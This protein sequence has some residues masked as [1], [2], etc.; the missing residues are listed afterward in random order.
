MLKN[1]KVGTK[2]ATGFYNQTI[3]FL[4]E[5]QITIDI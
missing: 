2:E 4:N 5:A 3:V 1:E